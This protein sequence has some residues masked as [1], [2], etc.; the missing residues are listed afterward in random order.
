MSVSILKPAARPHNQYCSV[1][2]LAAKIAIED[3]GNERG[4]A[5]FQA[6]IRLQIPP[7]TDSIGMENDEGIL[8]PGVF[9]L[10]DAK[11]LVA[12]GAIVG[13]HAARFAAVDN[14]AAD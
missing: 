13:N 7:G 4:I 14:D 10:G 11:K 12:G 5:T 8:G 1:V 6:G 9:E 2:S 3:A